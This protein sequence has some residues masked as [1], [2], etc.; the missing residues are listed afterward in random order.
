[1]HT[2]HL[3]RNELTTSR[4]RVQFQPGQSLRAFLKR[5]GTDD[6][7][8]RALFQARWPRGFL[9]PRCGY[10][11]QCQLRRR[12]ALQCIRCK[13]QASLVAGTVS[14]TPSWV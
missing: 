1:M 6:Q 12:K 14:R 11:K 9:C 10:H 3:I 13:Q 4:D 7:C 2:K 8:V 5:C